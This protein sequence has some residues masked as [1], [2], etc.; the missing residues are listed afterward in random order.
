[1]PRV[2]QTTEYT[3]APAA[4][5]SALAYLGRARGVGERRL[6]RALGTSEQAGTEPREIARVARSFGVRAATRAGMSLEN[7]GAHVERGEPVIVLY[8]AWSEDRSVRAR[9]PTS[10]ESGHFA[11]VIG[12][13]AH[14]VYLQDPGLEGS[15]AALEREDFLSRWHGL[16]AG[17]PVERLGIVLSAA[18][19]PRP[20][21]HR[22][23]FAHS[24]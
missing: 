2:V 24:P 6:A 14:R 20:A 10:Y 18:E 8:Q 5:K 7:L 9:Y 22:F 11:V 4:L 15:R 17:R 13:D 16:D 21:A 3:C 23:A 12:V 19:R 1:V